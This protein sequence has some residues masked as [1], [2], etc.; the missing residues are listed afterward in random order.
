MKTQYASPRLVEYGRLESLTL[1]QHGT[2]PDYNT[3]SGQ[4]VNDNCLQTGG[5]GESGDSNPFTCN[6]PP[7]NL[8]S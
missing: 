8:G 3:N 2:M 6:A 1:G 5:P 7:P 4:F